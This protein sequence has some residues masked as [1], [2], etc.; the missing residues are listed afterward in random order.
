MRRRSGLALIAGGLVAAAY[1]SS[2]TPAPQGLIGSFPWRMDDP[3]FGGFSGIALS[4]D[5]GAFTAIS[6]RGAWTRG[7]FRRDGAGRITQVSADPIRLLRG[8]GVGPLAAERSDS[9]GLAVARDGTVFVSFEGRGAARVLRY[10]TIDGPAENLP[11]PQAFRRMSLN[12]ALEPLAIAADGT[13]YTLPER[14]GG[15]GRPFPVWRFRDGA[16]DQ[17]FAL[18]RQGEWQAVAADI[19]PDGRFYLLERDLR[20]IAGFASRLRRFV[21]TDTAALDETVLIETAAGTH[22]NLEGLSVWRGPQGLVATM[23]ADDNFKFFQSTQ[24][25]EYRLP[26]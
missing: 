22:D 7:R 2:A 19:G 3:R 14:S 17:P 18:P 23:I 16:W 20:G 5:G 1:G 12:S 6:D 24:I 11:V 4:P 10:A 8:A 26:D 9:E 13:L 25:V 21:L 15:A